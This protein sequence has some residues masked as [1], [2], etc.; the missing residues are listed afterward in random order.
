MKESKAA[1]ESPDFAAFPI[2][3]L[4]TADLTR[5]VS[6]RAVELMQSCAA[7]CMTHQPG[8]TEAVGVLGGLEALREACAWLSAQMPTDDGELSEHERTFDRFFRLR[9]CSDGDA[10]ATGIAGATIAATEEMRRPNSLVPAEN[11]AMAAALH[12]TAHEFLPDAWTET[13][14]SVGDNNATDRLPVNSRERWY[15]G[16]VVFVGLINSAIYFHEKALKAIAEKDDVATNFA[17]R[18]ASCIFQGSAAA[19]RLAGDLTPEQYDDIRK[20]MTPPNLPE[21]FSGTWNVDH[22]QLLKLVKQLGTA[23]PVT[24]PGIAS[25]R[26]QY[27]LSINTAYSA[28]RYVCQR[29]VGQAASLATQ[30]GASE[31]PGHETLKAFAKRT[32]KLATDDQ[33]RNIHGHG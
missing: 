5:R 18:D 10:F 1:E 24:H 27:L 3:T 13:M 9:R 4:I 12:R 14:L 11:A 30:L 28:H 8:G 31:R 6:P 29:V 21:G 33:R 25:A 2:P 22:R 26:E 17:L 19:L 20:L 32:L 16:H 23:I 7:L 15:R